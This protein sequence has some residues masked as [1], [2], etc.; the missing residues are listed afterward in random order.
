MGLAVR[1]SDDDAPTGEGAGLR[2]VTWTNGA[3][4]A[5]VAAG[6]TIQV[7]PLWSG[8]WQVAVY[9]RRR[10]GGTFAPQ[11]GRYASADEATRAAE[12]LARGMRR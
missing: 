12:A 9:T 8:G 3:R 6:V 2:W 1:V 4:T 5:D 11:P 10:G 7:G